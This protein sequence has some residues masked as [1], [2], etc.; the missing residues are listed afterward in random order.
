MK[1]L[2]LAGGF[3]QIAL[4]KE[5]KSR[6]IRTLLADYYEN[7]VAKEYADEFYQISTLDVEGIKKLAVDQ[8]VDF[9]ITACT[10]QAL[11]TVAKVSEELGL[12]CYID[13]QTA[14][15]VTNKQYMKKVFLENDV[16]TAKYVSLKELDLLSISDMQYPLIVKPADCNS[17]KGVRKV[18][19]AEELKTAFEEAVR[20]SRTNTAIIEEFIEGEEITVD[21]QIEN[22]KAHVLSMA[23]SDKIAAEDKFVIYRTR[24]PI[25]ESD[26]IVEQIRDT[27]QKIADAFNLKNSLMLIQMISNGKKVFVLEFSARTGG[28]VKYLLI[29]KVSG[30]DVIKA[31]VDLTLHSVPKVEIASP[32]AKF[33]TNLFI[34]C[35]QGTFGSLYGFEELK[36]RMVIDDYY[37]FKWRG[38]ELG[39]IH[40]SGDRVAGLTIQGDSI[41]EITEKYNVVSKEIKVLD[42]DGNDIMHHDLLEPLV[43]KTER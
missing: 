22:G 39:G 15:N 4:I 26:D 37:V 30:F 11:L 31:V 1:A 28:G 27:A 9:V 5:L 32:Q 13:Y 20:Y 33:I 42:I 38:A 36:Q 29:K 6:N 19:H 40:S 3:P 25:C 8:K 14:L 17:S 43:Y 21:V 12:P 34:Y 24:Y 35:K 18:L 41:E 16:S 10:D 2:V 23:Y 7:P